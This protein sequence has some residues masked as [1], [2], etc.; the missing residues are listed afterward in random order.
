MKINK[1]F[2][3]LTYYLLSWIRIVNNIS[4]D[5]PAIIIMLSGFK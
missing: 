4:P 1:E 3:I 5:G 2:N